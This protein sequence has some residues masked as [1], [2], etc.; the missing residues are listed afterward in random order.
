MNQLNNEF[1]YDFYIYVNNLNSKKIKNIDLAL[2]DYKKN[3]SKR[4]LHQDKEKLKEFDWFIYILVNKDL[5]VYNV[6]D[7]KT[8]TYHYLKH[9]YKEHRIRNIEEL[10]PI[11]IHFN[12]I[13]YLYRNKGLFDTLKNKRDC[14]I[15]YLVYKI[16]D[17]MYYDTDPLIPNEFNWK[18]YTHFYKDLNGIHNEEKALTHYI[19]EG[20][21]ENR[22][23]WYEM[24]KN[25]KQLD[26]DEY[27]KENPDLI[28]FSKDNA[29]YHW[30]NH[31]IY[32]ERIFI[33][34]K[35]IKKYS[36][37]GIAVT[38]YSDKYTPNERLTASMMCLNY[39]FLMIPNCKIYLIIDG[40]ILK[41][42]LNFLIH[43]NKHNKNCF[44][45]KNK[46][47]Y[48]IAKTKNICLKLLSNDKDLDYYCLLDDD[49]MIK[50]DFSDYLINI[51]EKTKIP[52]ISNF[53]KLLPYFE[54]NMKEK[55]LIN[56]RF[57]LG[58]IVV[59]SKESFKK[60]GYMQKYD[61]KWGDEHLELTK[62]YLKG[63]DY[64]NTAIDFRIYINDYFIINKKNTLHLH[65]CST[66]ENEVHKN[67]MQYREYLKKNEYVDFEF[68]LN[69]L[70]E[71]GIKHQKY[72]QNNDI[73]EE[74]SM[75]QEES[76]SVLQE[77]HSSVLQE[78]HSSVLQEDSSSVLQEEL[79]IKKIEIASD[80][81]EDIY[82]EIYIDKG[83]SEDNK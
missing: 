43:L 42:H 3:K 62:R 45:Y 52:L 20:I 35:E 69:E 64:E 11:L 19:F 54:N 25:I 66:N 16:Q 71:I 70:E 24:Y 27:K 2:K 38:L 13:E 58:N 26:E 36:T 57:Y 28:K 37:L 83:Q 22:Y 61:S 23:D 40:N 32:E 72:I 15:H 63:S 60:Y 76:S 77:E 67:N 65:S 68:E 18:F 7:E 82:N 44:V 48:G 5:Q 34:N 51:F 9:G 46:K 12:W 30:L 56:S 50:K 78:E 53:N 79:L 41:N 29:I 47:N 55:Y 6:I 75:I 80:V 1:D 33:S 31:G 39:L 73:D 14:Y 49:I 59:V 17:N 4:I 21:D 8:A 74:N 10:E 81:L